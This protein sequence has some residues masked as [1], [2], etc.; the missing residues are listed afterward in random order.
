M[1]RRKLQPI[2]VAMYEDAQREA[3]EKTWA[4]LRGLR[5]AL[6]VAGTIDA[7]FSDDADARAAEAWVTE[8]EEYMRAKQ[9]EGS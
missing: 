5:T 4:I 9:R 7:E 1:A 2:E 3:D 8:R 6:T